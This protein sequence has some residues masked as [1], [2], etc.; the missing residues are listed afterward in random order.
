MT[1]DSLY[2]EYVHILN[3]ILQLSPR[4]AEVLSFIL[5]V[6]GHGERHVNNT[7]AR[8]TMVKYLGISEQNLSKYLNTLKSKG[9]IVRD[10]ESK[11]WVVNE[12]IR[13]EV[14]GGILELTITLD[15]NG[16][17]G[18]KYSGSQYDLEEN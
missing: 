5:A 1:N 10:P 11:K 8:R 12:Y 15:T 2:T 4:E 18:E 9:L 17:E 6:D 14:T 7:N 13:P 3:G 16:D